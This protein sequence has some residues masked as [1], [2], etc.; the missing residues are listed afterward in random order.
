LRFL[1]KLLAIHRIKP[2]ILTYRE[3]NN[4]K[5][6]TQEV[7][8]DKITANTTARQIIEARIG[9]PLGPIADMPED[10]RRA[11]SALA[12]ALIKARA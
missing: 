2:Y 3:G 10:L 8:M 9:R 6:D 7:H 12:K 4:A 11:V 5:P 1:K